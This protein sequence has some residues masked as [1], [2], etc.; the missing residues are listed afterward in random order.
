MSRARTLLLSA[1]LALTVAA[2]SARATE[3]RQYDAIGRLTDIAYDGGGSIHYTFDANGNTLSILSSTGTTSVG[4]GESPLSFELGP[5][6]PNPG[7]G[8]RAIAFAIPARGYVVLR[9]LD[10]SGREV[11]SLFNRELEP[12]RYTALFS[13]ARW[14]AGVYFYRLDAAGKSRTGRLIVLP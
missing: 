11:A 1:L 13:T 8:P 10:V 9:V 12:G 4:G 14:G 2:P 7:T 3:T 5:A 6:R